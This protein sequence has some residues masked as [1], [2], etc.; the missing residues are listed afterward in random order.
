MLRPLPESY[1]LE[2]YCNGEVASGIDFSC[3]ILWFVWLVLHEGQQHFPNVQSN[4]EL[5]GKKKVVHDGG[6]KGLK[7]C[8]FKVCKEVESKNFL[9]S[10][11]ST[12]D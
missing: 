5:Y 8:H 4:D 1:I 6:T 9:K 3:L 7:C 2:F 10:D 12:C 11:L